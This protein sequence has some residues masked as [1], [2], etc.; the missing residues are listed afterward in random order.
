MNVQN[1]N[2]SIKTVFYSIISESNVIYKM[3]IYKTLSRVGF[4]PFPLLGVIWMQE[5]SRELILC[6]VFSFH[7]SVGR[8]GH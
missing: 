4:E 8:A 7:S 1:L 3:N 5:I 2:K 6:E